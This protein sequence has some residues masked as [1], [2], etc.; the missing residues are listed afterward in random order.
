MPRARAAPTRGQI[1]P[2]AAALSPGRRRTSALRHTAATA[3][4]GATMRQ[5]APGRPR[6]TIAARAAAGAARRS[7]ADG[8]EPGPAGG[9]LRS[10][11]RRRPAAEAGS[12]GTTVTAA[13]EVFSSA[14][15][16]DMLR[17]MVR[18]AVAEELPALQP[19]P[20]EPAAP[21]TPAPTAPAPPPPPPPP[22]PPAPAVAGTIM[23]P[24]ALTVPGAAAAPPVEAPPP[25]VTG[26]GTPPATGPDFAMRA[27][28]PAATAA[29][30]TSHA[31]LDIGS[32]LDNDSLGVGA[33]PTFS[34]VDGRLR[35]AAAPRRP[36]PH[37][38]AWCTAFLRYAAV[39][40]AV[41]PADASGLIG[42]MQQVASLQS[43]GMGLA[44]REFDEA[45]R[46]ARSLQPESHPEAPAVP[47]SIPPDRL[48]RLLCGYDPAKA[49]VLVAGFLFGFELGG[50]DVF[51]ALRPQADGAPT[52]WDWP[53][54]GTLQTSPHSPRPPSPL[55]P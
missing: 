39:Y 33:G 11:R 18:A 41:H 22:P 36:V 40:L 5:A 53:V 7:A 20:M 55:P 25:V 10:V 51:R 32:L 6:Q 3:T 19:P 12:S 14:A 24:A 28:V 45:F 50:V 38:G 2:A 1:A 34:L 43:P 47:R 26:V 46:R 54:C 16:H 21:V 37:F 27:A 30:I 17:D 35:P 31:Y 13:A 4:T 9:A 44:W 42:H 23:L 8:G 49:E 52:T 29:L 15:L 48:Q